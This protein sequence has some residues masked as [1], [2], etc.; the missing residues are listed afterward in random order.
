M[1]VSLDAAEIGWRHAHRAD[2]IDGLRSAFGNFWELGPAGELD[3]MQREATK[4]AA[5]M[6]FSVRA[7]LVFVLVP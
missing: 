5:S 1:P 3:G 2:S 4:P 7:A 6:D